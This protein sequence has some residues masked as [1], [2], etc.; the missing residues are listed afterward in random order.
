MMKYYYILFLSFCVLFSVGCLKDKYDPLRSEYPPE[1]DQI[2]TTRCTQSGCHNEKSKDGAAGLDLS[3][4]DKMFNGGSTGAAVIPYSSRF[5]TLLYFVNT[6]SSDGLVGTPTMPLNEAPLTKSQYHLLRNW[7]ASGAPDKNGVV[8]FSDN[9]DRKKIY[10]SNQGCDNVAILD[11]G[12]K[13]IMRYIDVGT[14]AGA[15]PPETPHSIKV[16]P[17]N[18]YLV[19]IFSGINEGYMQVFDTKTDSLVKNIAI[20]LGSWNTFTISSDSRYAYAADFDNGLVVFV[21]LVAGITT[22]SFTLNTSLHGVAL[23]STDDTLYIGQNSSS[24]LFKIPIND[25][26]NFDYFDLNDVQP[27]PGNLKPHEIDFSPDGSKYFVTCE[28]SGANQVRVYNAHN[29]QLIHV[30]N[31]G[32]K[33]VEMSTS[34]SR[35]LLFVTCMEDHYFPFTTGSVRVIDIATLTETHV[36]EVGWQPHDLV[37]DDD[38][39]LVYV[40]NRN[41]DGLGPAPH[42]ASACNGLKNGYLS[43]IDMNTMKLSSKVKAELSVDP[44]SLT[45]KH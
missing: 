31:V 27:A 17:D 38:E 8:M 43:A 34:A 21:D 5:S 15:S 7:I 13:V 6:D 4:W 25:R 29:D 14:I 19:V 30:F 41:Y 2:I 24:G 9:P 28:G 18:K 3:T 33:P 35:N 45:I 23:N 11:A 32:T 26:S 10:I 12:L 39:D 16:T 1:V 36:I 22:T 44:Y 20:G 40:A 37:V 42:H